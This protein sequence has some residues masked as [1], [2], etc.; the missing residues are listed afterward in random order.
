VAVLTHDPAVEIFKALSEPVRMDIMARIVAVDE[1][2][3]TTLEKELPI[4]KST[5]SYHMK[6]L[7]RARLIDIRKDGRYYHYRA[8][9][10]D[11]ESVLP[12]LLQWLSERGAST[13]VEGI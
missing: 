8:R 10:G 7:Y 3:C 9:V 4:S 1:L 12:G 11:I 5:I 6:I 13:A 2:P